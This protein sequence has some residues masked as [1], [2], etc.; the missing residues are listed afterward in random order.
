MMCFHY[1]SGLNPRLASNNGKFYLI[2]ISRLCRECIVTDFDDHFPYD[3]E[4]ELPPIAIASSLVRSFTALDTVL[5]DKQEVPPGDCL[6]E[7]IFQSSEKAEL[8]LTL[9]AFSHLTP[10]SQVQTAPINGLSSPVFFSLLAKSISE[11]GGAIWTEQDKSEPACFALSSD[12]KTISLAKRGLYMVQL[13]GTMYEDD[14]GDGVRL[15]VNG[16]TISTATPKYIGWLY[17][18]EISR[19]VTV[20]KPIDLT[21]QCCGKAIKDNYTLEVLLLQEFS[22]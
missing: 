9:E 6:L 13:N 14:E 16:K 22:N 17:Y 15:L 19:L 1:E 4:Y 7:L 11:T 5:K 10:A 8:R 20:S 18:V 12:G 21:V 2:K 3:A